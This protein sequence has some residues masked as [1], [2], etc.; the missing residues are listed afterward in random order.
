MLEKRSDLLKQTASDLVEPAV[1][2]QEAA[3]VEAFF[4]AQG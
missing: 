1:V 2:D 3:R 4:T